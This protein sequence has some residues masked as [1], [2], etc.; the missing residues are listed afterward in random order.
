MCQVTKTLMEADIFNYKNDSS[1]YKI[2]DVLTSVKKLRTAV[3][4]IETSI[5]NVKGSLD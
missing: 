4:N 1:A 5:E 3:V 2:C